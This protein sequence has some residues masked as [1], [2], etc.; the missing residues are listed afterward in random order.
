MSEASDAI[1]RLVAESPGLDEDKIAD[2]TN[3]EL[4]VDG[5]PARELLDD[6]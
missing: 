4:E 5:D 3:D 2:L 1:V 6:G